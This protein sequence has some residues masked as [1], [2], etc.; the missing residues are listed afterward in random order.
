MY[1]QSSFTD[2]NKESNMFA[3]AASLSSNTVMFVLIAIIGSVIFRIKNGGD[4][5]CC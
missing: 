4:C 5:K 3:I 2:T 1:I